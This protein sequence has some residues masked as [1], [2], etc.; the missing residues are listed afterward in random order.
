VSTGPKSLLL[1]RK[2]RSPEKELRGKPLRQK[3]WASSREKP[4]KQVV[5]ISFIGL[6]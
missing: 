2:D 5:W 4:L 3:E 1:T 6:V